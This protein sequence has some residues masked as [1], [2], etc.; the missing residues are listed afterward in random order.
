M[1]ATRMFFWWETVFVDPLKPA[2]V[3]E[4]DRRVFVVPATERVFVVKVEDP[5]S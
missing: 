5:G 4:A 1:L 3:V 2:V